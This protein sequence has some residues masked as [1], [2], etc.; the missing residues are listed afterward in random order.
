MR[1]NANN[2]RHESTMAIVPTDAEL[3]ALAQATGE[4][5]YPPRRRDK[6]ALEP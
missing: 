1:Y 4:R 6:E 5:Q 2:F 3:G